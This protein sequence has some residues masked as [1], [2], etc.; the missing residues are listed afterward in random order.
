M[1]GA[2]TGQYRQL[3]GNSYCFTQETASATKKAPISFVISGT[4]INSYIGLINSH[5]VINSYIVL[6]NSYG[7]VINSYN[8]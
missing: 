7:V 5:V 2:C 8:Q 1:H 3:L 4:L 6:I